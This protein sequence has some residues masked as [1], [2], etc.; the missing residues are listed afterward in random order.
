MARERARQHVL[1]GQWPGAAAELARVL[2]LAPH[3]HYAWYQTGAVLAYLNDRAAY[4]RYRQALLR[5]F[6]DT[7][8]PTIAERTAK[9]GLLL[10]AGAEDGER[11]EGLAL[12][13]VSRGAGSGLLPFY[14][15]AHGLAAYRLKKP[16]TAETAVRKA[17]AGRAAPWNL[18]VPAYLVLAMSQQQRGQ[19]REAGESLARA[20]QLFEEQA[21]RPG[22][23]AFAGSWN[24]WLM[25]RVL[26]REAEALLR[27][28]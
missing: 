9:V 2:E 8:V 19:T 11:L 6:G 17:L 23:E 25:C 26:L 13:A 15:L 4:D 5:R 18:A 22:S 28:P 16:H 20:R 7:P 24:D 12:L 21:P 10:P 14:H 27:A 3:D 1:R